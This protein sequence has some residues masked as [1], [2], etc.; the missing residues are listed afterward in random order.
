MKIFAKILLL[1]TICCASSYGQIDN[2]SLTVTKINETCTANGS[3]SFSVAN[4]LPG[5]TVL[6]TIYKLPNLTTPIVVTSTSPFTGLTAGI[7]RVVATQSLGNQS[8]TKQQEVVIV[9]QI[10]AL[11]YQVTGI[12]EVCG[13]DGSITITVLTGNV[14]NYQIISGPIIR[15]LQTSNVFNNLT[16]GIYQIRVFDVCGEG[17][18]QTYQLFAKSPALTFSAPQ[19]SAGCLSAG[20]GFSFATATATGIIKYP[21]Q[22]SIQTTS[23]T[24]TITTNTSVINSGLNGTVAIPYYSLQPYNYVITV[25]DGCGISYTLNGV[26]ANLS[27]PTASYSL[28]SQNCTYK[29]ATISNVTAVTLVT[30]P[31]S[32]STSLPVNYTAQISNNQ[33]VILN[34]TAGTY[35]FNVTNTCGAQQTLTFTVVLDSPSNPYY[36]LFN[37]TCTTSSVLIFDIQSLIM[38]AAPVTY[39]VTLPANYTSLINSANYAAFNNLPVGTYQ[40]LTTDLCGQPKP[41]TV[42]ISPFS[43]SP[44]ATVLEGC[45]AGFGGLKVAGQMSSILMTAAPAAYMVH[46][47]P[48]D[49]TLD[50]IN[51]SALVLGMLPPGNYTF[52]TINPCN[53]PFT[54][55]K[56]V[57]GFQGNTVANHTPNCGSF[58]V[59]ITENSN[60][61]LNTYWLQKLDVVANNWVH[62]GTNFVYPNGTL[63]NSGNSVALIENGITFNLAFTGRFR[64]LKAYK[65]YETNVENAIDCFIIINEFEFTGQ[66]K[67]NDVLSVSCGTTFEVILNAEG[68]APLQY[69]ITTK[70]GQPFL[71]QNGTSNYFA[72]LQPAIYNF[73][74]QDA[75]GNIVNRIFEITNP[76]PISISA[77]TV[78]CDGDNFTLTVPNF[79]FLQY[80]WWKDNNTTLILSTSNAFTIPSFN[81]AANNGTYHVRIVYPNNPNSCLNQVLSYTI[82]LDFT[83]PNA[84]VGTTN[85]YCGSQGTIDLFTLLTGNYA[86]TGTWTETTTSGFLTNNLWNTAAITS[87]T[88]VFTYRV[89]GSC[90]VVANAVVSITLNPIPNTPI[91]AVDAIICQNS[92]V[93]LFASS[94]GNVTYTWSG[95]DGFTSTLQNPILTNVSSLNNGVYSVFVTQNNCPS[96]P[97]MVE[98]VVNALPDFQLKQE[99]IANEYVVT[100]TLN[101]VTGTTNSFN[102]IGPNGFSSNQNPI[103]ITSGEKGIYSL[104]VTSNAGCA[105]TKE[106]EVI[107]TFCEIP[108][109]ITPNN[110]GAND[111]L[112]LVGFGVKRIEI[113]NRWGRIVYEKDN[114]ANEW[115]GQN[116]QGEKLPDGTYFYLISLDTNENKNGW[117][118]VSG[119]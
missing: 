95:P 119:N 64:I 18:V 79:S 88:Y 3:L 107:R 113:F 14:L 102:W 61:S 36:L 13:N 22:V 73:R 38:T 92:D 82:N 54:I 116:Q 85:F 115:F 5:A 114:Y 16:A 94:S 25:I 6:Y 28:I 57:L 104:T 52:N 39:N 78:I 44:T 81:A 7:Y 30:A 56:T 105:T 12:E 40:F 58:N 50:L 60:S 53:V 69:S 75:C 91:A 10:A 90:N 106:I 87:G 2:F 35:V 100:A 33:L 42:V 86:T 29:K 74:V 70:N 49:F 31:P 9:S 118:F 83:Q 110:D 24:G 101:Q 34:L 20:V 1:F 32:F 103:T 89:T 65:T 67:I 77:S 96:Q 93:Q 27:P 8:A 108:N 37:R 71:V 41:L 97:D 109:V 47:I 55:T 19:A 48:H 66:P 4:T 45:Q 80:Q 43:A 63:P 26:V 68:I 21:L 51:G 46:T 17:V 62:P 23:A 111:V 117:I 84:G 59:S 112:N 98:V 15:P 76:N 99:C 11:T 72:N